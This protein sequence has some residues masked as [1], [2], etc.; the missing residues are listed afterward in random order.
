MLSST[1]M[2]MTTGRKFGENCITHT[3]SLLLSER[4]LAFCTTTL[5][6]FG[7][8]FDQWEGLENYLVW[9]RGFV[10]LLLFIPWLLYLMTCLHL[11]WRESALSTGTERVLG[12]VRSVYSKE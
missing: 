8:V 7:G 2:E 10:L 6:D 1:I 12:A 4:H 5:R 9:E 3:S 11:L